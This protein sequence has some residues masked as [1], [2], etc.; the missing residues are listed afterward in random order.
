MR[1]CIIGPVYPYRGGIAHF[2]TLLSKALCQRGHQALVVSFKRQY[3]RWLFPGET[4]K[5]P[6]RSPLKVDDARYWLDSV[7]PLTWLATFARIRRYRPEAIVM[8][9][10]TTFWAPAWIVLG[11]LNRLLLRAELVYFCHNVLPHEAR[12]WDGWLAKAT[13]GWASTFLVQSHEEEGRMQTLLPGAAIRVVPLPAFDQFGDRRIPKEEARRQ[14]ALPTNALVLL[15]FGM[16]RGYKG[17][18]ELLEAMPRIRQA[19]SRPAVLLVAGEFW[20]DRQPYLDLIEQLGI[21]DAVRIDGRYI[22]DEEV[23]VYF[24]AADALAAPY[25]KVTGSAV[26]R[27]ASSFGLPVIYSLTTIEVLVSRLEGGEAVLQQ[28]AMPARAGRGMEEWMEAP[29]PTW[30]AFVEELEAAARRPGS[31][32]KTRGA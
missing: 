13:L 30:E 25:K 29:V 5:D 12:W 10:W 21:G 18:R 3:P 24:C 26:T 1:F 15:F 16:V 23:P 7:N 28:P 9:W 6:S 4:D 31:V 8:Q 17:L 11:A 19:A 20:E 32:D 2:T 22:P 14:L 27:I